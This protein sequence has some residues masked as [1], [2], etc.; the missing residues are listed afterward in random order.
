MGGTTGSLTLMI[1]PHFDTAAT[2]FAKLEHEVWEFEGVCVVSLL[3]DLYLE[4]TL[5]T[6]DFLEMK[7]SV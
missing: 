6:M 5:K 4:Y 3:C 7:L 2:K 1:T